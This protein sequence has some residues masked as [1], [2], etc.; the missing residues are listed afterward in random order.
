[1]TL[2]SK[3]LV[4]NYIKLYL[5]F[6]LPLTS[7]D[8]PQTLLVLCQPKSVYI[9]CKENELNKLNYALSL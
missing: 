5:A 2:K 9:F 1:M 4:N 6:N 3:S 7:V 8:F